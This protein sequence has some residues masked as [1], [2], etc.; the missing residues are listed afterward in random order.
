MSSQELNRVTDPGARTPQEMAR[1]SSR[2]TG[3]VGQPTRA[4]SSLTSLV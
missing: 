1:L 2:C 4:A 3:I